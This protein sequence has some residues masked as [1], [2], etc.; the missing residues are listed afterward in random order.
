MSKIKSVEGHI[1][2]KKEGPATWASVMVLVKVETSDGQVGYGEAVPTLRA[3]PLLNSIAEIGRV[4]KGLDPYEIEKNR[5]EW[6]RNDFYL[7]S[8]FE[9]TSAYSAVDIALWDIVGK[10]LGAPIHQLTGG[11][12]RDK[13]PVYANGWYSDCRT[14]DDFAKK[15][16]TTVKMGYRALKF[17][18][19]GSNY[20]RIDMEGVRM[21]S[22]IV[23][24][25]RERVGNGVELM[26]EHHGRFNSKSAIMIAEELEQYDPLFMEE[27][28]H[29]NDIMGL[30]NYRSRTG[31]RV[32]LGERIISKEQAM[33]YLYE[34]LVDILQPD[35]CNIGGFTEMKKV[36]A[37]TETFGVTLA[38][39]NAFGPIQNAAT[40]QFDASVPNLEIQESFYDF[41]PSWKR[42][43]IG[44]ATPVVDGYYSVS[45]KPGLGIDVDERMI[46]EYEFK[47]ME[48]WNPNEPVWVVRGT[49]H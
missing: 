6:E 32:A 30:R 42:E 13:I 5:R 10:S 45:K 44:N 11:M 40:I 3:E 16:D 33:E 19:F 21:S 14:P 9:S 31:V 18:P 25:V 43:L 28:V 38:P 41:F 35:I 20:D 2:G 15:A 26:I 7:H 23:R 48:E 12:F 29:P 17:D 22:E 27:P 46:K 4:Y 34:G 8:S 36:A 1:L 49:W 24:A 47:G 37:L 39:H